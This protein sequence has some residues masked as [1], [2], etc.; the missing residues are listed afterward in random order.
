[1]RTRESDFAPQ[2]FGDLGGLACK[3]AHATGANVLNL[4]LDDMRTTACPDHERE[5]TSAKTNGIL[6]REARIGAELFLL[7]FDHSVCSVA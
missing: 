5:G 4:P 6:E 2:Q 3:N 1:M 7:R